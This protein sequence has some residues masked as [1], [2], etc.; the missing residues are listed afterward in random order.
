MRQVVVSMELSLLLL[1]SSD[2]QKLTLNLLLL[3]SS[4][5]C[6]VS[7]TC[8]LSGEWKLLS[9]KLNVQLTSYAAFYSIL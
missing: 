3:L 2:E 5:K 1:C 4:L 9:L 7:E 6:N 8:S